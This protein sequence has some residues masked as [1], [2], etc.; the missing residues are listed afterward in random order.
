MS[1]P[2]NPPAAGWLSA[3]TEAQRQTAEA[4]A[5]FQRS[6]AE[7]HAAYLRTTEAGFVGL[8]GMVGGG[9][10]PALAASYAPAPVAFAPATRLSEAIALHEPHHAF[11]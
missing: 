3:W 5:A 10:A 7:A 4:H 1:H 8:A 11:G 9:V 2:P 6:M